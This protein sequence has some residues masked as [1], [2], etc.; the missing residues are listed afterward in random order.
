MSRFTSLTLSGVANGA[1]FAAVALA[2]VL[3]WRSTRIVNFAQG[4][5]AMFTAFLALEVYDATGSYVLAFVGGL[6]AGFVLGAVIERVLVRHVEDKPPLNAVV[7]TLGLLIVLQALAGMLFGLQP[8]PF[9]TAVSERSLSVGTT[10]LLSRFDV[11]VIVAV[12][13]VMGLLALLFTRTRVGLRMRASAFAPEVSRLV[14]VRVGRMLTLGWALAA[15]V[16]ALAAMLVVAGNASGGLSPNALDLVFVE[17]FTA[18]IVGG[19]DSP[20]G[21][22]LGGVGVGLVLSYAT[23]YLDPQATALASF[24]VLIAVLL[25][26]PGGLFAPAQ[27]RVV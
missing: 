25:V 4:G 26:R 13:V 8:R 27:A 16:G 5:M 18:A 11:F 1:V 20:L 21:A 23:G 14:G 15:V 3:I 12:L 6:A 7:V 9:P 22:V 2:L 19:L 24:V 10:T 17:G